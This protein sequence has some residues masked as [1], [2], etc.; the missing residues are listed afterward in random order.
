[1]AACDGDIEHNFNPRARGERDRTP[2]TNFLAYHFI[3]IHALA[4]SATGYSCP[5]P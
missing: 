4:G 2:F 3:S 1:M 5:V